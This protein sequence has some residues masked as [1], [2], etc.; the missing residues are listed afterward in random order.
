VLQTLG[1]HDTA[2]DAVQQAFVQAW[3]AAASF[4]PEAA[5]AP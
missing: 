1:R 4:A 2:A 5:V 3:K